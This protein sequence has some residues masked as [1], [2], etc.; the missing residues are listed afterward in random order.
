MEF[1]IK[2]FGDNLFE[3]TFHLQINRSYSCF[4]HDNYSL[5][6]KKGMINLSPNQNKLQ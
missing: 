1:I 5:Y 3:N 4:I 6:Y 2:V